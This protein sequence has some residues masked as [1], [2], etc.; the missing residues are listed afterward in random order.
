MTEQQFQELVREMRFNQRKFFQT[1]WGSYL[2]R[3]KHLENQ[4]DKYLAAKTETTQGELFH[5]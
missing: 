5:D 3:S 1:R 2:N 4:V